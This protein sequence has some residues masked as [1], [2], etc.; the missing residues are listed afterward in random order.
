MNDEGDGITDRY[1]GRYK[2]E[3]EK[4]QQKKYPYSFSP[5]LNPGETGSYTCREQGSGDFI[6]EYHKVGVSV[7][8]EEEGTL[9]E[10]PV[11]SIPESS[12]LNGRYRWISFLLEPGGMLFLLPC[13]IRDM[14]DYHSFGGMIGHSM[15]FNSG[16]FYPEPAWIWGREMNRHLETSFCEQEKPDFS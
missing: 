6:D 15:I 1:S 14:L 5:H 12:G 9:L 16:D 10:T 13:V 3:Y 8:W 7:S 2:A 4:R 11:L